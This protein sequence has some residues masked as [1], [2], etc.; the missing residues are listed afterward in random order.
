MDLRSVNRFLAVAELGSLNKAAQRLNL[1]QPALS[2]SIQMLEY[3]FGVPLLDRGPRGITLTSFG[4][5]VFDHARRIAAEMRKMESDIK[6]LRTLGSGE[7]NVGAPLG[8][9]SRTLAFAILRLVTDDRRLTINIA[10][11]TRSDLI[12][13]LLLG[14]LDFLIA[15]L[16]EPEDLP[17]DVEQSE[18]YLD[19][20]ILVVRAGH[21]MLDGH[22]IELNELT[23][24]PWVVLTG[25]R[26]LEGALRKLVGT[27][28]NKS[29]L[30]SGS[31]MFVKNI[32]QKSEFIGLVRQDAVRIEL[33]TGSLVE[34]DISAQLDIHELVPPQKVGLIFR[35]D[36]S[37]PVASQALIQEITAATRANSGALTKLTKI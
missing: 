30:R 8:P 14:D 29:V 32:L 17:P 24:Y 19:S 16:F 9:D 1:S 28:F 20:M 35:S 10:N 23:Q 21:P 25:N 5:A 26:D 6:A 31:P 15:T 3:A 27:E 33:E 7:I 36:V 11:G 22:Q 13:P 37:I 4:E 34:I 2:K 18:L 12:R